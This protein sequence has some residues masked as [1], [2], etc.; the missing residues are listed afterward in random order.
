MYRHTLGFAIIVSMSVGA[1]CSAGGTASNSGGAGGEG[2]EAWSGSSSGQASSGMGGAGG[3]GSSSNSGAGGSG[4]GAMPMLSICQQGCVSVSDCII[5]GGGAAFDA[6]NYACNGGACEYT[7]C[8]SDAECDST[9][10]NQNYVC[11]SVVAGYPASCVK[12]CVTASDCAIAGGGPAYDADN[13]ACESGGCVYSGCN[14]DAECMFTGPDYVCRSS[15]PGGQKACYVSCQS[16]TDCPLA[17]AGPAFDADN[18]SC[19]QGFCEY[20]GCNSDGECAASFPNG[21]YVCR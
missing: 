8:N 18:Y 1:G 17:N 20:V 12:G 3:G 5:A 19:S 10:P 9:F 11:R 15:V 2:G 13:Y 7:G 4:G 14:T 16:A 6:D 21:S